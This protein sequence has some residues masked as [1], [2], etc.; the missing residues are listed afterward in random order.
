[1]QVVSNTAYVL[2]TELEWL[3]Y[4]LWSKNTARAPLFSFSIADTVVMRQG[5]PQTW[6]FSSKEGYILKKNF[7]NV[8]LPKI[9]KTFNKKNGMSLSGAII[10][11]PAATTYSYKPQRNS[12]TGEERMSLR[13]GYVSGRDLYFFMKSC[14]NNTVPEGR[15]HILQA[16]VPPRLIHNSVIK[17]KW[18]PG[19]LRMEKITNR[20]PIVEQRNPIQVRSVTAEDQEEGQYTETEQLHNQGPVFERI[21]RAMSEIQGHIKKNSDIT[22]SAGNFFFKIGEGD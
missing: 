6:Y 9:N 17:V 22:I 8:K 19:S 18:T 10:D 11:F 5:V 13:I 14:G 2:E 7:Q 21:L 3:I 15:P 20:S 16:F 4:Q 12:Q 1:M